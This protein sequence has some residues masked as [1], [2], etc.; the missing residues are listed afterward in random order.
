VSYR[1]YELT[2]AGHVTGAARAEFDDCHITLG[3]DT[4]TLRA[5]LP[6]QAA[7]SGLMGR[8]TAW[9]YELLAVRLLSG[10]SAAP[11]TGTAQAQFV[12]TTVNRLFSVG[13]SLM[14]A[15]GLVGDGVAADRLAEAIAELDETIRDIRAAV[16]GLAPAGA[17][18]PQGPTTTGQG[19]T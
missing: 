1:T 7:L 19:R 14:N 9:R 16:F 13:L 4:T 15:Q 17:D 8:I 6:D 5:D 2:C 3:P 11:A 12:F 18:E 10:Q